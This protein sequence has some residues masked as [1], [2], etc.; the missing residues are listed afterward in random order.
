MQLTRTLLNKCHPLKRFV[1][2]SVRFRDGRRPFLF[3]RR[4]PPSRGQRPVRRSVRAAGGARLP[5]YRPGEGAEAVPVRSDPR[6]AGYFRYRMRRVRCPRCGVKVGRVPWAEGKSPQ[7]KAYQLF[8]A[9]WARRLS[10]KETA[11]A[12]R[13]SWDSRLHGRAGGGRLRRATAAW[14]A[15]KRSGW[16]RSSG[17]KA[18]TT[19][20]W[21]SDRRR[22]EKAA[23]MSPGTAPRSPFRVFST[24]WGAGRLLR[25]SDTSCS[26]IGNPNSFKSSPK[27]PRPGPARAGPLPPIVANLQR[28]VKRE[29]GT[30]RETENEAEGV[31]KEIYPVHFKHTIL[32][33]T[34]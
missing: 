7:T 25:R 27:R 26:D 30:G 6:L 3:G 11:E 5:A 14:A 29:S 9:R 15:S 20:P 18:T 8:L 32:T 31:P 1:Y 4:P 28:A 10:W 33:R 23:A 22:I 16:T 21:L 24:C 2:G 19:S 13:T 17:A 12:F 34:G